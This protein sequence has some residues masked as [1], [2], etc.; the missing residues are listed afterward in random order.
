MK[1]INDSEGEETLKITEDIKLLG[2]RKNKLFYFISLA[3]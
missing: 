1:K 2:L 3:K